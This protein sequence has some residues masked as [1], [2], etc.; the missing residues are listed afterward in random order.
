MLLPQLCFSFPSSP[1]L[2]F[3]WGKNPRILL[4][5]TYRKKNGANG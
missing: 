2:P 3:A 1:R 5:R 4:M